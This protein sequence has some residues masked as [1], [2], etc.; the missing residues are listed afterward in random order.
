MGEGTSMFTLIS[1]VLVVVPF[2][3]AV[4]AME[5]HRLCTRHRSD[6]PGDGGRSA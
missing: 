1:P 5:L 4:A 6:A 2:L 3:A